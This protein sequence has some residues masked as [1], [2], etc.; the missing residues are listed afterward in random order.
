MHGDTTLEKI[1]C[2]SGEKDS[3]GIY[4]VIIKS[5]EENSK[6]YIFESG[7]DVDQMMVTLQKKGDNYIFVSN[8]KYTTVDKKNEQVVN[9]I[10]D[11]TENQQGNK[12]NNE[13]TNK[14]NSIASKELPKTGI[15]E[16]VFGLI[17]LVILVGIV[18][19]IKLNKYKDIK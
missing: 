10:V 1:E 2:I 17:V 16:I 14:D 5:N 7:K 12:I 6:L 9:N 15:N 11:K 4:K 3:N 18:Y 8:S 13:I 19:T